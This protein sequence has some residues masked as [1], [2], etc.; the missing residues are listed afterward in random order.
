MKD[1]VKQEVLPSK[2]EPDK[3]KF[4]LKDDESDSTKEQELKEEDLHTLVLRRSVQERRLPERYNPYD[5]HSIFSLSIIDDDPRTVKE[6]VDSEDVL[7][8]GYVKKKRLWKKGEVQ[9]TT[10]TRHPGHVRSHQD[11]LFERPEELK[12]SSNP[13]IGSSQHPQNI[14]YDLPS[15][16][17]EIGPHVIASPA[18]H[19]IGSHKSPN[20]D[21]R[22]HS[23]HPLAPL[24]NSF[25]A[26]DLLVHKTT[27]LSPI[28]NLDFVRLKCVELASLESPILRSSMPPGVDSRQGLTFQHLS[29]VLAP[30][31]HTP[32]VIRKSHFGISR[33]LL[34]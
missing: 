30:R 27:V 7:A 21:L 9:T 29:S 31:A 32:V 12:C 14:L 25:F 5:F 19:E 23:L 2:E 13:L 8:L 33:F 17:R 15:F 6:A 22:W 1:A 28:E 18:L 10:Q 3:I 34:A 4:D 20:L 11:L 16:Y 26:C 24:T